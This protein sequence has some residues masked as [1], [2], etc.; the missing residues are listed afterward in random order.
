VGFQLSLNEGALFGM[1]QGK[2]AVF[3]LLSIAAAI[4][5]PVWL[6]VYRA[7]NDLWMC[8]ALGAVLGG[9]LGNLYDR[10]GM[11][12]VA[13]P[14]PPDRVG[15]TAHAVRDWILWQYSDQWRWPNFNIAD[16]LLVVGAAAIMLRAMRDVKPVDDS[17]PCSRPTRSTD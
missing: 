9:I 6:F 8:V 13:W 1:G 5:I 2:V 3:A 4:A 17:S 16:S 12:D 7:A 14:W 10:L 15:Q 11:H